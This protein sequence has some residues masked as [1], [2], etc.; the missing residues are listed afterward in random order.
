MENERRLK[1]WK[2]KWCD[3]EPLSISF[4]SIFA[5]TTSKEAWIEDFWK[6][7]TDGGC[8]APHFSRWHNDWEVDIVECFLLRLQGRRVCRDEE[9]KVIW[10]KSK[11]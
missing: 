6:H 8:W 11:N 3:D 7:S 4:P 5:L 2:D 10:T 1:L 9:D